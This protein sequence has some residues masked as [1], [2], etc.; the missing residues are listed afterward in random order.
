MK[1]FFYA[2]GCVLSAALAAVCAYLCTLYGYGEEWFISLLVYFPVLI[3]GIPL[4]V[5]AHELGHKLF[6]AAVK[7]KTVMRLK[8]FG[9]A[10]CRLMPYTDK[11]LKA[12]V[13]F[14]ALGGLAANALFILLG[15]LALTIEKIPT[16]LSGFLPFSFYLLFLNALPFEYSDGKTDG[17][18]VYELIKNTDS[19]KVMLA[20]LTVQARVLCGSPIEEIDSALLF[21]LPQLSEDDIN[22]IALTHLRYE[23]FKARGEEDEAQKYLVRFN[24]LQ[25][26]IPD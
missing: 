4:A 16:E 25:D 26:Y 14:T 10:S 21:D 22:F 5:V 1:T 8:I 2:L 13:I 9:S 15:V 23:Y 11:N 12:R 6:G 3:L 17:L 7:I 24:E 19:A 18:V 20:V